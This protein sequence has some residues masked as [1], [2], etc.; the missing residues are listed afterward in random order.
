MAVTSFDHIALFLNTFLLFFFVKKRSHPKL[1]KCYLQASNT[2][3]FA[4][5]GLITGLEVRTGAYYVKYS[6]SRQKMRMLPHFNLH[7]PA[8]SLHSL[9]PPLSLRSSLDYAGLSLA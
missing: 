1:P 7:L 4:P 9:T 6:A 2:L 5:E 8:S 3:V